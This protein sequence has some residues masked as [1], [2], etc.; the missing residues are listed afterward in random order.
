M[1][2]YTSIVFFRMQTSSPV[3]SFRRSLLNR[4]AARGFT[5]M[6]IL[7]AI[8][9]LALLATLAITNV[10][11]IFGGAQVDTT[12]LFV[13]ESMSSPLMAYRLHMGDYPS[14]AEGLQALATAPA[15]KSD[16]WRGPYVKDG[17]IPTDPWGEA[18]QYRYPGLRNKGGYDLYSKGIDKID[19][20]EDDIGNWDNT[21]AAAP[22]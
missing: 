7:I 8:G 3:R 12:H 6:E 4:S 13:K 21:A 14:T 5:L 2:G 22:K 11:G 10:S 9:I 18:Y 1:F 17:K 15:A 16:R 19:G 20:N